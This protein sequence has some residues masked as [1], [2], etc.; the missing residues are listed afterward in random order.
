VKFPIHQIVGGDNA[1][2]PLHP[3]RPRKPGDASQ[4]HQHGDKT[5]ADLNAHAERQ[6]SVDAARSIGSAGCNMNL[7]DQTG[8][9]LP[10]HLRPRKRS[11]PVTVVAGAANPK[12]TTTHLRGQPGIDEAIDHRVNPSGWDLS[13]ARN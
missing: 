10:A 3:C 12:N 5:L 11:V 13:S 7:A 4:T 1:P 6:L 8:E 2:E 9:P